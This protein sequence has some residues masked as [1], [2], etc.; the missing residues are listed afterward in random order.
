[1]KE[2]LLLLATILFLGCSVEHPQQAEL[3]QT[4]NELRETYKTVAL[5]MFDNGVKVTKACAEANLDEETCDSLIQEVRN[6]F[7]EVL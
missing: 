3:D 7:E 1:M 5:I 6:K 4:I 2:L